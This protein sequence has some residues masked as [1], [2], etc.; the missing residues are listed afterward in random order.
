LKIRYEVHARNYLAFV[1]LAN[2]IICFRRAREGRGG[3]RT[4]S[5]SKL[6]IANFITEHYGPAA[7]SQIPIADNEDTV[8]FA[9]A[10]GYFI[11]RSFVESVNHMLINKAIGIKDYVS[12]NIER[13]YFS[14]AYLY[15]SSGIFN[16]K[17]KNVMKVESR[18]FRLEVVDL[19]SLDE[20]IRLEAIS[21]LLKMAWDNARNEWENA[22]RNT[23]EPDER[24][25]R[26][27]IVDEAH[28]LIPAE[29]KSTGSDILREE[30]R[31][32]VAEGRKFGLFLIFISQRPDKLDPLIF[33]ECENKVVMRLN[34]TAV[35]E[36][37]KK[38]MGL[39]E[40]AGL[41]RCLN[42]EKGRAF[43]FGKWTDNRPEIIYGAARRTVEGGRDLKSEHWAVPFEDQKL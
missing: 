11:L 17:V 41:D 24:V 35:L 38:M 43:I 1:H 26:F 2:A 37:T 33:S 4:H 40:V 36:T 13:N 5:K 28:N 34:S 9:R 32:I 22:L 25:P 31:R 7:I 30:F 29:I 6:K 18:K 10:D 14:K 21:A 15:K 12:R 23:Q 42:F 20:N 16:S 39:E 19:P 8:R 27:I 3:L